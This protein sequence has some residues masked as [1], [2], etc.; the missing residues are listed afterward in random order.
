M[1]YVNL[2]WKKK[3]N[4]LLHMAHRL[5]VEFNTYEDERNTQIEKKVTSQTFVVVY[6]LLENFMCILNSFSTKNQI[7]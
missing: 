5:K 1:F 2:L 3:N 4:K 7:F 6:I